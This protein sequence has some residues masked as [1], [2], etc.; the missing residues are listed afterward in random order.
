M[1]PIP[2]EIL[3]NILQEV[4]REDLFR[5]RLVSRYFASASAPF[6]FHTVPLWIGLRSLENLTLISESSDLS[7]CVKKIVFSTLRFKDKGPFTPHF[8]AEVRQWLSETT[9]TVNIQA[10]AYRRYMSAYQSYIDDQRYLSENG[11]DVKLLTV[12]LRQFP[13]LESVVVNWFN[14][15]LGTEE[16]INHFGSLDRDDLIL[17]DGDYTLPILFQALSASGT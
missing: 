16:I 7:A 17:F 11:L 6:L 3:Q 14:D 4:L 2:P 9:E 15:H 12:A 5:V 1:Q 13:G 8:G 10:L